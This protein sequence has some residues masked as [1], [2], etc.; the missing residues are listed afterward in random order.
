[1]R[2]LVDAERIAR[3][4]DALGRAAKEEGR[5]YFTGGATA[6]LIGWRTSTVDV[7][8]KLLPEQDAARP[9]LLLPF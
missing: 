6:V 8:L 3:L 1:M 7:D 5:V 2:E 9:A 4:M